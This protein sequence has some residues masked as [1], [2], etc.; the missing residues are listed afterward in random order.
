MWVHPQTNEL[1]VADGYGNHRVVVF[2]ADKGTFKRMWGAFGN[3]PM[4]DDH[5]EIVAPKSFPDGPGPQNFSILHAIRVA[6][7]GSVY[8]ADR[9][10]RRVQ[11]FTTDGKFVKQLV[12]T[13]TPFARD[14]TLSSD[15]DQR[16][17]Y[18]GNG[19]DIVIVD[20]K[21]LEPVGTIKVAGM[22]GGGHLIATD[23]KGNLYIA[24]TA[25]GMQK[26][27]LKRNP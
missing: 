27:T 19:D 17:L 10:N 23:S 7:D 11:M 22:I 5:C 12:R 9:E 24:Q 14:L 25:A 2:D 4:D 18:V 15:P 1:F 13:G 26:L 16:F 6:N 21:S 8:V 3:K 20:R